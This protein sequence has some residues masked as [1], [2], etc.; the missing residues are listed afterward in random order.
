MLDEWPHIWSQKSLYIALSNL[1]TG[2]FNV[3]PLRIYVKVKLSVI[4]AND[5]LSKK[6]E[7]VKPCQSQFY[8]FS[9]ES[10]IYGYISLVLA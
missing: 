2:G 7:K 1:P 8:F 6:M 4:S 3:L 9:G 5:N 10:G